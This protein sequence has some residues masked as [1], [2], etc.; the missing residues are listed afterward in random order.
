MSAASR[1]DFDFSGGRYVDCFRE[2][3]RGS[4]IS[5]GPDVGGTGHFAVNFKGGTGSTSAPWVTVLDAT[6]ENRD[7]GPTFG[8]RDTLRRHPGGALQRPKGAGVVALLNEGV[9]KKGLALILH[10]AA[11]PTRWCWRR[12]TVTRQKRDG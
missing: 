9:G 2:L 8:R 6:P 10:E 3:L 11:T 4:E 7:P 5:D 1:F 12:W